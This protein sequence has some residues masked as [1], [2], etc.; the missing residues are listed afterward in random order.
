MRD[1]DDGWELPMDNGH[2]MLAGASVND[3]QAPHVGSFIGTI[4]PLLPRFMN[5]NFSNQDTL[6]VDRDKLP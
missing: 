3:C 1:W 2:M 5:P 6:F 4:P